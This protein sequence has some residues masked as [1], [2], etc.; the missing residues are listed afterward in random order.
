MLSCALGKRAH[1][2]GAWAQCLPAHRVSTISVCRTPRMRVQTERSLSSPR[3]DIIALALVK[4]TIMEHP[5]LAT[6]LLQRST[7]RVALACIQCRSRKV[8]CDA[9]L[10]SCNRCLADTKTCRYQKSRRGG[11]PRRSAPAPL[12]DTVETP[13]APEQQHQSQWD[14]ISATADRPLGSKSS[15]TGTAG[16]SSQSN[17]DAL[18]NVST[19]DGVTLGGTYLTQAQVNQLLTKYYLFFHDAHPCVLPR[20]SLLLRLASEPAA[21]DI[22]L[23]V[24]LYIGSIFTNMVDSG[25]LAAAASQAVSAARPRSGLLSPYYIQALLLYAIA[26]YWCNEPERGRDLLNDTIRG[27]LTLGMQ[28]MDFASQYGQG[29]LVL[30]ESWRRTWWMI[31]ITDAHIAGSTHSFPTQSG[32]V[33]ITTGL[34]CEEHEYESGVRLP[35]C[36]DK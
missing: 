32:A 2:V 20:W 28:R 10:P 3:D 16:S 17:F 24:L 22:L 4:H 21:S 23:P 1:P 29:D 19:V 14:E 15:C 7:P 30:Q 6:S 11:R 18:V 5:P 31:Y 13:A 34:P 9:T 25:P 26:V 27:A 8:R 36:W 35:G 33:E 12:L